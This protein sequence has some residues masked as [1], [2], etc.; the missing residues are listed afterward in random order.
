LLL[1]AHLRFLRAVLLRV[2]RRA[3]HGLSRL[4]HAPLRFVHTLGARVG[5]LL[6]EALLQL[7]HFFGQVTRALRHLLGGSL[8]LGAIL[9]IVRARQRIG[10]L[11]LPLRKFL[12]LVRQRAHRSFDRGTLQHLDAL[13][14][15]LA[16]A[17]LLL[18]QVGHRLSVSSG[19]NCRRFSV[20]HS[21]S[22]VRGQHRGALLP[23][24]AAVEERYPARPL[25]AVASRAAAPTT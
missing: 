17:L 16:Q 21:C 6:L 7:L 1:L 18:R 13:L 25:P 23:L 5:L 22:A 24:P 12:G 4:L 8:G 9:G 10:D 3:L 2:L 14:E 11:P 19:D 20:F 15:L